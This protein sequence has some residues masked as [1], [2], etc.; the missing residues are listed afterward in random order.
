[1]KLFGKIV[2]SILIIAAISF[3]YNVYQLRKG[4]LAVYEVEDKYTLTQ[5]NADLEIVDFNKYSCPV[6]QE[7][8]PILMEAVKRD[9]KIRYIPR[10]VT[11]GFIWNETLASAVYAAA[12]QGKF[13]EMHDIIYR[14]W[15]VNDH[16]TLFLYAKAIGLDV[17]KLKSDM[18][19]QEIIDLVRNDQDYFDAWR[20][21]QTPSLLVGKKAV[22]RPSG[23]N[24]PTVEE[25]LNKFNEVRNK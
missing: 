3:S 6:C 20:L 24:L 18:K 14:K 17:E 23:E 15:P 2:I 22:Y 21:M 9:G 7:F 1:M 13:I 25:L 16:E 11:H 19:K 10:N 4:L 12:E 5:E 8:Y